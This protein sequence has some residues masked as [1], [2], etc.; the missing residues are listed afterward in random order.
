M[1]R[2]NI[3]KRAG[4]V[5]LG[6]FLATGNVSSRG[7]DSSPNGKV[8]TEEV[9]IFAPE[10]DPKQVSAGSWLNHRWGWI[11]LGGGDSTREDIERWFDAVELTISI[12]GEEVS[13]HEQYWGEIQQNENG[14]YVVWWEY[15]THPKAVGDHT[16]T[17]EFYYPDGYEDLSEDGDAQYEEDLP[18]GTRHTFT[19]HYEVTGGRG[20][21]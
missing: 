11:D 4:A 17:V 9:S 13:N 6:G 2:R 7:Q 10:D 14:K 8:E 3:L 16:F 1:N 18:P 5:A 19:G 21:R 15:V 12:D 20:K